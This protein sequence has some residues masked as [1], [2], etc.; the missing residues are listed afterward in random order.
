MELSVEAQI[1]SAFINGRKSIFVVPV[2]CG[3]FNNDPQWF[4]EA[5]EKQRNFIKQSGMNVVVNLFDK[6]HLLDKKDE[7]GALAN[8]GEFKFDG[9]YVPDSDN[10]KKMTIIPIPCEK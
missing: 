1:K 9:V 8:G 4:A 7:L 2:A 5:L 10:P 3:A 6:S